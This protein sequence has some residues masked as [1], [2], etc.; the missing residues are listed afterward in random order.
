MSE[1]LNHKI[2]LLDD[3]E[4]ILKALSRL[5]KSEG[6]ELFTSTSGVEALEIIKNNEITIII[7]DQRM[8]QMTG[9]EFLQKSIDISPKSIRVLLTGYADAQATADAINKGEV[10]YFL[11]KPWDDNV[12]LSRIKESIELYDSLK[13]KNRLQKVIAKQNIKL[14][15]FN[16]SL[17]EKVDKQTKEITKQN[18]ELNR[19]FMET[20]KA[21]SSFIDLRHKEV[22]SHSQRVSLLVKKLLECYDLDQKEYQDIIVGSYLHDIGKIT[23]SDIILKKKFDT[24]TILEKKQLFKHPIIGQSCVYNISGFGEI[25]IIIRNHHENHDGTGYPDCLVSDQ[26]P[27]GSKIIRICNEFD[28]YAFLNGYPD[29][30]TLQNATAKLVQYSG[31]L[32]DPE[33]IKR[34]IDAD[35]AKTLF[36]DEGSDIQHLSPNELR[37]GMVIADDIN[38]QNGMFLLPK[39][40]KLSVDMINRIRK[41][42]KVDNVNGEIQIYKKIVNEKEPSETI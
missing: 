15:E 16:T 36:H 32:F 8:P 7:S 19:S 28:H 21:F 12:L 11:N 4:S 31:S 42:H 10:R 23:L 14:R 6:F 37:E 20:I 29:L 24:L 17:K 30:Q 35:V 41:I 38:T 25:G 1:E 13:E 34:F 22:G 2:L 27:F 3:E 9:V 33:I 5:L 18:K 39:G 26:I 40:A